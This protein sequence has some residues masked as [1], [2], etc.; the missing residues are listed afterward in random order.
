M[1]P[2]NFLTAWGRILRGRIPLLSIEITR[3]CPLSCPGCYAYGESH[4][5]D[6]AKLVDLTDSK[7]DEL[8]ANIL[9]L[10]DEHQPVQVSL[11][12]GEPMMRH[13][14]LARV[15][16]VLSTRG[17]YTMIVTSAVIPIPP[18]WTRMPFVTIAVSVDGLAK[19]HDVRRKP[20]TYERILKN[21]KDCRI[22]VHWTVVN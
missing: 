3:E 12:G 5:A 21:I 19:D 4:L 10:V 6:G 7:G 11:V 1:R 22:N 9:R 15:L 14:E 18:E 13:R 2:T 16:P 8:V 20:A 17:I